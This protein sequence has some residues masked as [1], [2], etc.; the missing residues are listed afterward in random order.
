MKKL[1][2][3]LPG[4]EVELV[5]PDWRD[6]YWLQELDDE[7]TTC[8]GAC[9]FLH[10]NNSVRGWSD[11]DRCHRLYNDF[12]AGV[13]IAPGG[14]TSQTMQVLALVNVHII[15]ALSCREACRVVLR[16]ST[17]TDAL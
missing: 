2:P 7:Q 16:P 14:L 10:A 1:K 4:V 12:L 9:L 15:E 11:K 6:R 5:P 3:T 8:T 17:N 13:R